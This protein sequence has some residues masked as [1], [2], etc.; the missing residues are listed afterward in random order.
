[1]R[2][3]LLSILLFIA[4][5]SCV[6]NAENKEGVLEIMHYTRKFCFSDNKCTSTI[7]I[8]G[9]DIDLKALECDFKINLIYEELDSIQIKPI[10]LIESKNEVL[11]RQFSLFEF[12]LNKSFISNDFFKSCLSLD[13][14]FINASGEYNFEGSLDVD[15]RKYNSKI[16]IKIIS[17]TCLD[18]TEL[19]V[20]SKKMKDG[21]YEISY[22]NNDFIFKVT[23]DAIDI[24]DDNNYHF[25]RII[26]NEF[27]AK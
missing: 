6:D 4:L 10:D 26:N 15:G 2:K 16:N 18:L 27:Y 7:Y 3:K 8:D 22:Y 25:R 12:I 13:Y 19:K 24:N 11:F 1:M 23:L 14:F 17:S 9:D 20:D 5:F 21:K